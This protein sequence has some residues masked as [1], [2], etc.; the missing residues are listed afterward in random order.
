MPV[1]YYNLNK[2]KPG[3]QKNSALKKGETLTLTLY[4]NAAGTEPNHTAVRH[5]VG[6]AWAMREKSEF[7]IPD[8]DRVWDLGIRYAAEWLWREKHRDGETFCGFVSCL[9]PDS[10][11][12]FVPLGDTYQAGWVVRNISFANVLLADFLK[13]GNA[14]SKRKGLAVLDSWTKL[15][16]YPNGL[17]ITTFSGFPNKSSIKGVL[18][19]NNLGGAAVKSF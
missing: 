4:V 10:K 3:F 8:A 12:N 11:G 14:E 17:L 13:T 5:F 6:K 15:C 1:N 18:D 19:A 7:P 9:N 2:S 16:V